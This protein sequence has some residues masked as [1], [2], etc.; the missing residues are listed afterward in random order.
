MPDCTMSLAGSNQSLHS[1]FSAVQ[2]AA[3]LSTRR[4]NCGSDDE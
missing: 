3:S 2:D 4:V 1:F